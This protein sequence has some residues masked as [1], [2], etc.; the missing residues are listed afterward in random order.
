[1]IKL[2]VLLLCAA[3]GGA[4]VIGATI[5]VDQSSAGATPVASAPQHLTLQVISDNDRMVGS[6]LLVHPGRV[7]LTILNR[8]H[9]SHLFSVPALGIQRVVLPGTPSAPSRTTVRFTVPRGVFHW[10]CALPCDK[11]MSGDIYA[12][13]ITPSV[14][15]SLWASA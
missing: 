3:A 8:A 14:H 7:E 9:H 6:N 5:A 12:A 13:D 11:S 15:G 1:M 10:S 4:A 2:L